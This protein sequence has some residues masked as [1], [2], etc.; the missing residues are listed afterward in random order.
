MSLVTP[1]RGRKESHVWDHFTKDSLGSGHYAAK[2]HYCT[3]EWSRGKPEVL[4][5]HLALYCDEVP[6]N[7]KTEYMELLARGNTVST[8]RKQNKSSND[9]LVELDADEIDKIDRALIRFFICCGIPLSI[10]NHPYFIDFSQS[11]RFAYNPPKRTA[12][13]TT[14]LNREISDVLKKIKEELKY[15][16]N[17]TLGNYLKCCFTCF[18]LNII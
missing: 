3:Q 17:L 15:E 9:S 13:T 14:I 16:N 18:I 4:K 8:N 5:S 6:L 1:K 10:V 12:L 11:L 2:C 7:V